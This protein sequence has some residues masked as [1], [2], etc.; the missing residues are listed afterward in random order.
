MGRDTVPGFGARL[1]QLREGA[2]LTIR[3][4]ADKTGTHYTTIGKLE[5]DERS[6]SLRLAVVL[7]EALGVNVSELVPG[8]GVKKK[9]K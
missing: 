4:L 6:V 1:K 2:G 9:G 3:A 7:A 8:H 5:T